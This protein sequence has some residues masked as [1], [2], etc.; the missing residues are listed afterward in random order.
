MSLTRTTAPS[1][2]PVSLA[3]AK[4]NCRVDTTDKDALFAVYIQSAREF[5]EG[6][7]GKAL[8]TQ[9]WRQQLDAFPAEGIKLL[10]PPV[11]AITSVTYIDTAGMQ[12]TLATNAYV[13]D[14]AV[15]PGWL[16][17]AYGTTWPATHDDVINAVEV[18]F[19]AGYSDDSTRI[20]A[21][22]IRWMLNDITTAHDNPG[23]I[24]P[25]GKVLA[26]PDRYVDRLLD[27]FIEYGLHP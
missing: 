22:I 21:K 11:Q 18:T 2:E 9:T 15:S 6:L 8:I 14:S 24:D 1:V 27:E 4:L 10:K 7:T 25:T 16:M 12:Q 3:L 23:A 5:V 13:L 17:P 20:P 19:T 26:M